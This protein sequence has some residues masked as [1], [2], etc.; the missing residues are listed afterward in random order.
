L[1]LENNLAP[2]VFTPA[3]VAI[4][5]LLASE[6]ATSLDN[7]RLYREL[8]ERESR[9]RR[10][11]DSNIIGIFIFDR[12][13]DIV[14]A[15]QAFLRTLGYSREDLDAGRLH[16][17][18]LTPP[19]WRD[20]TARAR[21]ELKA[22]GV[23]QPFEKEFFRKD[24]S[25]VPV[26]TG[27]A[28]FG[29]ENGQGVAFV[30][31]LSER[32]R[33][34]AGASESERRYRET[35]MELAHANRVA[36][37][38]Q[39]TASIAHEINQPI[40]AAI[41]YANA[42]LSWLRA[43]PPNWEEVRQA[44]G[45]IVESAVR[46]GEVIDRSRAL[47]KKAPPQKDRVDIN[48]AILEVLA[49]VHAEIAKNAVFAKT[50]LG[51]GIPPVWGDRVQLQQVMLNLFL[52]AIE[53]MSGMVEGSRELL[54]STEKTRSDTVLVAVRDSGPGFP[55]ESTE[56]LFE[57]FYTTKPGGLGMGLSI[58]HSII[59]AHEGRLWAT[60]S[61]SHGAVFQF[62]LRALSPGGG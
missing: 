16:W 8:Q 34:E 20:R 24:G 32:K 14:D 22:T 25:R 43:Q 9:I 13:P 51:E 48:E 55:S 40:G 62:T 38:G 35:Q 6:A 56:R 23:V 31:D 7:A 10:L 45:S 57:S 59:E 50:Q 17:S 15:N 2:R 5:K 3:R 19:E 46:A 41:T 49:L 11:V 33:A 18:E 52:N 26:L 47:V 1:Y 61:P 60:A 29:D 44:L 27:G 21:A 4:L 30:L 42:A 39:L 53:A 54:I 58:C 37:M 12:V 36:V 28:A